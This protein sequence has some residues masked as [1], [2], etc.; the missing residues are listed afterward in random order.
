MSKAEILEE[1][2]K[3]SPDER[4][5]IVVRIHE[6]EDGELTEEEKLIL[7]RELEEY[8]KN[9]QDGSAWNEVEARI[10]GSLNR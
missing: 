1:L 4:R 8:E 10:R 2:A 7:D 6:L 3:L 9:P 5:E